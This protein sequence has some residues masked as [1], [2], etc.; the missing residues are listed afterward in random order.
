MSNQPSFNTSG[1]SDTSLIAADLNT[2]L[3]SYQVFYMNTRGFHWNIQGRN[4]FEMHLKF[5][6][7]YNDLQLKIDEIAE[8]IL[9]LGHAPIH[10]FSDCL[11][12]S[13]IPEVSRV[14]DGIAAAGH[15]LTSLSTL[16]DL[17]TA[18]LRN[19]SEAGDEGTNSLMSDYLRQQEKLRWMYNAYLA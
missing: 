14:K 3:A 17:Q 2:L 10:T 19:A 13:R 7:L 15:I 1:T 5:E 8:R 18:L 6:E 4:F 9:T 16:I 12:Q 11:K